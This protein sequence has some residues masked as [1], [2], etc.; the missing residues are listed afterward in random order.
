MKD[1]QDIK[2]IKALEECIKMWRESEREKHMGNKVVALNPKYQTG[3]DFYQKRPWRQLYLGAPEGAKRYYEISFYRGVLFYGGMTVNHDT[4][5][6][7]HD[8]NFCTYRR[9]GTP[10]CTNGHEER[11]R[12]RA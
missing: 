11:A 8:R 7:N 12:L 3:V 10:P 6:E 9:Q 4:E 2:G 1:V 5:E